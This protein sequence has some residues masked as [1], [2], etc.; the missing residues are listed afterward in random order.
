MGHGTPAIVLQQ[1]NNLRRPP[2][3]QGHTELRGQ[4]CKD[5]RADSVLAPTS[6]T[7]PGAFLHKYR[8][9]IVYDRT[10]CYPEF[11]IEFKRV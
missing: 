5:P 10:Q 3:T 4:F 11:L 8:E 2:C 7:H 6:A 1:M 9:F